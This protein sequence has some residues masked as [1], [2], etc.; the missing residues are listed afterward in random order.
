MLAPA[1]ACLLC[2]AGARAS[3]GPLRMVSAAIFCLLFYPYKLHSRHGKASK[4]F[5][6]RLIEICLIVEESDVVE[7]CGFACLTVIP[8]RTDKQF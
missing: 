5:N 6:R 8:A 2:W 1:V 3:G 7:M 4:T